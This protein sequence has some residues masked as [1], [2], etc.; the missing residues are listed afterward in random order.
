MKTEPY[1]HQA[2]EFAV[3]RDMR[4]RAL[5]W[6]MRTGKTKVCIDTAFHLFEQRKINTVI[7]FAPQGVHLNWAF[8]ELPIHAWPDHK[9]ARFAWNSEVQRTKFE[10]NREWFK[11]VRNFR[12][13]SWFCFSS[14][15]MIR[16]DVRQYVSRAIRRGREGDKVLVIFDESHE[17][18]TPGA[19]R[20]RM[21]RAV[22]SKCHYR[23]ILSG[24]P[25]HNSPLNAWGQFEL[26]AKNALGYSTFEKFKSRFCT[27]KPEQRG[28]QIYQIVDGYTRLGELNARIKKWASQVKR[29]DC[30]DLPDLVRST[31]HFT[32]T[33][34][35]KRTIKE[36]SEK[37]LEDIE[38]DGEH[39]DITKAQGHFTRIQQAGSGYLSD[40]EKRLTH[41]EEN[42]RLD[43]IGMLVIASVERCIVWCQFREDIRLVVEQLK[44]LG[45]SVVE[46][47]GGIT[48]K[49]KAEIRDM[50]AGGQEFGPDLVGQPIAGGQGL[51]LSAASRIIWYSHTFDAIIREQADERATKVGGGNVQVIDLVA[52]GSIDPY[53]LYKLKGKFQ[54]AKDVLE[55]IQ[56]DL[57][58]A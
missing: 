35:Q 56:L 16:D 17:Y 39:V 43:A 2:A 21:A 6:T 54:T 58:N 31:H 25:V 24:T 41:F 29:E 47:H 44:A 13:L 20:S 1:A 15:T 37:A 5:L 19:K 14:A 27:F 18:R 48:D 26:L 38:V 11:Q 57:E 52:R 7:V 55:G 34:A 46:Y 3:S 33:T 10:E 42:P 53:I 8:R 49:R 4:S 45:R 51:D 30:E 22:A 32:L 50:F 23:R 28:N 40:D 36:L 9:W 12:G